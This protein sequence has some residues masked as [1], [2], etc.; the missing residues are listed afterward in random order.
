ME[1]LKTFASFACPILFSARNAFKLS[2]N[3][4]S[5]IIVSK[6]EKFN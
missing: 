1:I 5:S 6:I 3:F 4:M 2:E